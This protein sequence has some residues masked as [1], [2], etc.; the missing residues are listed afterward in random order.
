MKRKERRKKKE[1][2][3]R[4]EKNRKKK[5]KRGEKGTRRGEKEDEKQRNTWTWFSLWLTEL[6]SS[7]CSGRLNGHVPPPVNHSAPP[8]GYPLDQHLRF[9][10]STDRKLR[11]FLRT[12]PL[13]PT[14]PFQPT[15]CPR[16]ER[17]V[18]HVTDGSSF[19]CARRKTAPRCVNIESVDS[20]TDAHLE[21]VF[22]G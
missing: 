1:E 18:S 5:I 12:L 6:P 10:H 14:R 4:K 15:T 13:T 19:L 8:S 11:L 3:N 9:C 16:P 17:R 7:F 21:N 22:V 20:L 2:K